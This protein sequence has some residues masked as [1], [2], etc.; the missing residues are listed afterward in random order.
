MFC[1]GNKIFIKSVFLSLE[2]VLSTIAKT[3]IKNIA[4]CWK[5]PIKEEMISLKVL[6][7]VEQSIAARSFEN[8]FFYSIQHNSKYNLDQFDLTLIISVVYFF[9]ACLRIHKTSVW[10]S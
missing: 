8:L 7:A 5:G 3:F 1:D 9:S 10:K 6:L 2:S 4:L